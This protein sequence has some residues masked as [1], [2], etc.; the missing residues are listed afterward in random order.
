MAPSSSGRQQPLGHMHPRAIAR[1]NVRAN[2]RALTLP[3]K[4]AIARMR[5]STKLRGRDDRDGTEFAAFERKNFTRQVI[6]G[7]APTQ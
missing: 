4:R 3:I 7:S 1:P 2:S 6:A 5:S